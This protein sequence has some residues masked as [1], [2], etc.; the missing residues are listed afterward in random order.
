MVDYEIVI[1]ENERNGSVKLDSEHEDFIIY[2]LK[3]ENPNIKNIYKEN[4]KV[5]IDLTY[6]T[7][8][9]DVFNIVL[10][11]KDDFN[12]DRPVSIDNTIEKPVE[13]EILEDEEIIEDE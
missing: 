10:V 7:V 1:N 13:E 8:S 6:P 3:S 9:D 11:E 5:F 12:F 4:N 2:S